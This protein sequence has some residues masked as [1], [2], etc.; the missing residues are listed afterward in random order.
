[1]HLL[2]SSNG[3][4]QGYEIFIDQTVSEQAYGKR[5]SIIKTPLR[6]SLEAKGHG[7]QDAFYFQCFWTGNRWIFSIYSRN[8]FI[9]S[10]EIYSL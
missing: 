8:Y 4:Y 7:Q 2:S 5:N 6:W 9:S 10:S 1:M 3:R